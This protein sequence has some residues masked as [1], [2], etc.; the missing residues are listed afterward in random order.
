VLSTRIDDDLRS[1]A[2]AAQSAYLTA[3][4]TAGSDLAGLANGTALLT[5]AALAAG[6]YG[7]NQRL[8][9]YR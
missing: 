4:G 3:I 6:M 1:A 7:I 5:L 2:S 8:R 9:E